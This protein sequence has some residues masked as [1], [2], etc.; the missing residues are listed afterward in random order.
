[1]KTKFQLI[2]LGLI[3]CFCISFK[4]DETPLEKLLKQLA[5]MTA[6]YPQEKVHLHLDKPYYA[7]GEDMWMKGYVVTAER[8]EPSLLSAVLYVE[9]IDQNNA[10][11]KKAKLEVVDGLAYGNISLV[12]SL[13]PGNYRIRAYTIYMRNYDDGFF[14]QKHITLGSL[15]QK[16]PISVKKGEKIE[17]DLQFFP[18][19]GNLLAGIRGKVGVKAVTSDGLGA[20]L[21][22]YI[23]NRA[24]EKIAAFT[25]EHAG[26]GAFAFRPE[27]DEKYT[28]IVT[29]AGGQSQ[30]FKLPDVKENGYTL[31]LTA[32][33]E[34]I[35]IKIAA[36]PALI[37]K[38]EVL[39]V[40]QNNGVV[41][42]SFSFTPTKE[43]TIT[44]IKLENF[45][46]GIVQFTVFDS[47]TKPL[48][49]RLFFVN[50][51]D[52]MDIAINTTSAATTK[53]KTALILKTVDGG[54]RPVD[55][56]FSVSVTDLG[57]IRQH[58]DDETTI[59][60]NL[61][62]T[63]DLNGYIEQPNYYF[64]KVDENKVRQLDNLLLTQGWR[65]FVWEDIAAEKEPDIKF[66]PELGL[67]ISGKVT[68]AHDMALPK[69][70][71]TLISTTPGFFLK[72]D[73]VSDVKGNFVFDRLQVPDSVSFMLKAVYGKEQNKDIKIRLNQSP[74]VTPY[75][76]IGNAID[77]EPY[78][79]ITK[80]SFQELGKFKG[81]GIALNTVTVT[82][83]REMKSPLNVKNSAN[84][85]G[86]ANYVV[87]A[88]Q[89]E[90]EINIY[91]VFYKAPGVRVDQGTFVMRT[92]SPSSIYSKPSPMLLIVDG[93]QINQREMPDFLGSIN[94]RDVE[95]IEVLTSD[96]YLSVL[97]PDASSGAIY[98]TTKLGGSP[99]RPATNNAKITNA[100]FSVRKEFYVP[101]YEDPKVNTQLQDLRSTVYW[102]PKV[103]TDE[104]GQ[105][106]FSFFNA[107]TPGTYQVTIEGMDNF[108]NL[109]RKV[110]T[111]EVK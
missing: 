50:H 16:T 81:E 99:P 68:S 47:E 92:R 8:N 30:A 110:Y 13:S 53:G 57:K 45:P 102:N 77:I 33:N 31:G 76:T 9:L 85:S 101:N 32:T 73:T 10:I 2:V 39:V 80:K 52:A 104:N 24:K 11:K 95:G 93:V 89:L 25:T 60:S 82:K 90:K 105:A 34:V 108:G 70:K 84:A 4:V 64:N 75:R 3:A 69:A 1:M 42:A 14:F 20:N 65:R 55:G 109:G 12:D 7:I 71:V 43:I 103:T 6:S 61:L 49:E 40:A 67:E 83:Q 26:M 44:P 107:G 79:E 23:E 87:K 35:N 21:S 22:G 94:P 106:S 51:N 72:L 98:I 19:G 63:S 48:T 5:K 56:N 18:E 97:G 59:L 17:L 66:R 88:E 111:Y 86:S 37:G 78:L 15:V 46:T 38:K 28:A 27:K 74:K 36:T 96:Y 58:E 62:L 54:K 29:L 41:Y 91:S 100:G